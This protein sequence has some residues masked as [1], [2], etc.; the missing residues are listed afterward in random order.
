MRLTSTIICLILLVINTNN[1]SA[2]AAGNVM[3]WP[4]NPVVVFPNNSDELWLENNSTSPITLQIRV[5]GWQQ[6]AGKEQYKMHQQEVIATP[7]IVSIPAKKKQLIR[8]INQVSAKPGQERAY[9]V[10]IDEIPTTA[11]RNENKSTVS[12]QMRYSIPL[13]VYGEGI[14]IKPGTNRP[15]SP[16]P[17]ALSW[18][19]VKQDNRHAIEVI[20]RGNTHVRLSHVSV[21]GQS[22]AP[23]LMGYVLPNSARI[24]PLSIQVGS[25]NTLTAALNDETH[26]QQINPHGE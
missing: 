22:I 3:I 5:L 16:Y 24:W 20:N 13:F 21:N 7:P 8:L 12:L 6:T 11:S 4:I 14:T 9:R 23:G 2:H 18:R 1:K 26:P 15:N 17:K 10:L 19:A 25:P